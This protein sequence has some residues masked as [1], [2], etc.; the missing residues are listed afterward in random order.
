MKCVKNKAGEVRRVTN[1]EAWKL[2]SK[3]WS[4]ISKSEWKD[5][6]GIRITSDNKLTNSEGKPRRNR[7]KRNEKR[8]SK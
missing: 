3:G 6:T 5:T 4:Y 2:E 1:E 7:E 8:I